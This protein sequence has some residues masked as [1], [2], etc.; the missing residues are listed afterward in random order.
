MST[1]F[2]Y[3]EQSAIW[4]T[5]NGCST[6]STQNPANYCSHINDFCK[7]AN[8]QGGCRLTTCGRVIKKDTCYRCKHYHACVGD[9]HDEWHIHDFCDFWNRTIPTRAENYNDLFDDVDKEI[10]YCWGFDKKD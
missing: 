10:A 7:N 1:T 6:A 9:L 3:N 2:N 4:N 5:V 8:E